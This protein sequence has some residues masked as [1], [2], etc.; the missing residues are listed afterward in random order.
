MEKKEILE[1]NKII[2]DFMKIKVGIDA[3]GLYY[4]FNGAIFRYNPREKWSQIMS[5]V[6]E[7]EKLPDTHVY[8]DKDHV[9]MQWNER[10]IKGI[11]ISIGP[12]IHINKFNDKCHKIELLWLAVVDFIKQYNKLMK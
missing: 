2:S 6:I 3:D 5:V 10:I 4:S 12:G 1:G 8:I 9:L 11:E 7:I